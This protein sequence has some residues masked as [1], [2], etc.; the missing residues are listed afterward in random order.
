MDCAEA[1]VGFRRAQA[2]LP[3]A[4]DM[5]EDAEMA[6]LVLDAVRAL[7]LR[8]QRDNFTAVVVCGTRDADTDTLAWMRSLFV[9][10]VL[11]RLAPLTLHR[12]APAGPLEL[13]V[14]GRNNLHRIFFALP[15]AELFGCVLR[16]C[17]LRNLAILVCG[18]G[19]HTNRLMSALR[20]SDDDDTPYVLRRGTPF[21]YLCLRASNVER[22]EIHPF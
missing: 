7:L 2:R 19:P 20:G 5:P 9:R 18:I 11:A 8:H 10:R 21:V 15:D 14:P 6:L 22:P 3:E 12:S 4:E 16:R 17:P 1:L 13:T